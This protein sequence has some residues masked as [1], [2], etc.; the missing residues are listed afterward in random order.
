[1]NLLAHIGRVASLILLGP[2]A[3]G[4]TGELAVIDTWI[5]DDE[6]LAGLP[7]DSSEPVGWRWWRG[8]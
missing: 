8:Q 3:R 4:L 5:D 7:P 1:M 6:W 2:A